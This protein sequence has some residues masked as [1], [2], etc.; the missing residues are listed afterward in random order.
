MA[1]RIRALPTPPDADDAVMVAGDTE[2][3][4]CAIRKVQGIPMTDETL[5]EFRELSIDLHPA[6]ISR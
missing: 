4:A 2:K 3:R 6:Q 1:D 5:A